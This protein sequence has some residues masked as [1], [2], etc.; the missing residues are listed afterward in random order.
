MS[1]KIT[2]KMLTGKII[3]L[4]LNETLTVSDYID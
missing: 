2:I 3:T 4:P 1:K